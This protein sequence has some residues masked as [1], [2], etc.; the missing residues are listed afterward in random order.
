MLARV[1]KRYGQIKTFHVEWVLDSRAIHVCAD[2][3][4]CLIRS[5]GTVV[6]MPMPPAP[7]PRAQRVLSPLYGVPRRS[8]RLV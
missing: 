1:A 8:R 7:P 4:W 3:T 6:W 2:D 5:D